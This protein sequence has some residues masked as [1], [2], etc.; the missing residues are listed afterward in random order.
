MYPVKNPAFSLTLLLYAALFA[1]LQQASAQT[2][3]IYGRVTD[4]LT[5]EAVPFANIAFRGTAIGTNTDMD[6]RYSLKTETPGD[7]LTASYVG[8][9][10]VTQKIRKG[11]EQVVNFLLKVNRI[12]L[13][14]VVIKAGENPANLLLRKIIDHKDQ[15]DKESL[16]S[17]AY[18]TYNKL[19]FD[20]TE[21]PENFKNRK[22]IKP[23]AFIFDRV[24]SSITNE[25][26]SI[27]FFITESL[28]DFYYRKNPRAKKEK[29][30]ASKVSGM[31]NTTITQFLGDMYQ[32]IDVYDNYIDIFGKS[33]VSPISNMGM[34]FYKYY[35][36]DSAYMDGLWCYKLKFKPRRKQELTF[37]GDC[38]V[39][40]TT[41]AIKKINMRIADDANIN[42]VND[43]GVVKE[44]KRVDGSHWMITR[45]LLVIDFKA[46]EKGMGFIGRKTTSYKNFVLNQPL[47]DSVFKGTEETDVAEDAALKDEQFWTEARHDSLTK[48]ERDI[49]ALV[50]TIKSLPVFQTYVD[51]ITLFV[52]GY[53]EFGN[54]PFEFGPYFTLFSFN[55]VEGARFRL[56]GRTSD[57]FSTRYEVNGYGAYGLKDQRFKYKAGFR[58][59]ITKKPRQIFSVSYKND[60]TQLA[61][62]DDAFQDDN[63]LTSL[64]RRSPSSKLNN[65]IE[66][67]ASYEREWFPGFSNRIMLNHS[68]YLPLGDLDNDSVFFFYNEHHQFEPQKRI[69]TAEISLYTR[70]LYREKFVYG[71]TGRISL[72][73]KYPLVQLNYTLGMKD[74]FHSDFNYHKLNFRISD[75]Y[76][77]PP[78]GYMYY[79]LEAGKIFG[80][81]PYPLLVLHPGNESY[82]YDQLSFNLMNYFEFAS[83]QYVSLLLS[84]HFEG[85]LL[86]RIPLMRKLKWREVAT[87]HAVIGSLSGRNR[88]IFVQTNEPKQYFYDFKYPYVELSAGLENIFKIFRF[89]VLWRLSYL[90][91][92][93]TVP[94]GFRAS[95]QLTF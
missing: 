15:N 66:K 29:I 95:L 32:Q 51:I 18:E 65:V 81:V 92:D 16:E 84:Q 63:I 53:K 45:D 49:Y 20:L 2:T 38:W 71:K 56:G 10:S 88:S 68:D 44:Y 35:L 24:D 8:Y 36:T 86:N 13:K 78:I 1:G 59:F 74:I 79:S 70:F 55:S 93:N 14:E 61:N 27:P 42:F 69:T 21:I 46:R 94:L 7:S 83:E 25:K 5:G 91:H 57:N 4:V 76:K 62:S 67:K 26:P 58:W 37:T 75:S 39:H 82:F 52:T 17:Y 43:L 22:I 23:F 28:S 54:F 19:E 40:D 87:A 47:D 11:Q 30:R 31:E 60:V 50:D 48:R 85:F 90:D 6:G 73:S 72:G 9:I 34:A 3:I 89:D 41:F 12:E 33:F 80:S 64:F 77:I